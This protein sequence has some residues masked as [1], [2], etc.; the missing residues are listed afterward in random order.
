MGAAGAG[1]DGLAVDTMKA[2]AIRCEINH[3]KT[4]NGTAV[5]N[6][7]YF[8][9]ARNFNS[10]DNKFVYLFTPKDR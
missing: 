1:Y 3:G 10:K 8:S 5:T 7:K 2:L 4:Y 6:E 9:C